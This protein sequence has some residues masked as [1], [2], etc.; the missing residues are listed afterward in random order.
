MCGTIYALCADVHSHH[1]FTMGCQF[2]YT[3]VKELDRVDIALGFLCRDHR[4]ILRAQ[5]GE[6][7][8]TD[9]ESLFKFT[10]IGASNEQGS[11]AY[12]M[13]DLFNYDLRRDSGYK[14]TFFERVQA[15]IDTIW[16][17]MAKELFKAFVLIVVAY[18]LF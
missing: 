2:D 8:L 9:V 6:A 3:R 1:E 11:V 4:D 7:V 18:L 15:N 5:L 13:K 14:K 17:D 16:F 10:W 12:K